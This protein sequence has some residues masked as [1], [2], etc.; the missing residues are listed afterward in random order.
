MIESIAKSLEGPLVKI[1]KEGIKEQW[2]LEIVFLL[3]KED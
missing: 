2:L 3:E 1:M